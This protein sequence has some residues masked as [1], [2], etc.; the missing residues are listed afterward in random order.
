M[1]ADRHYPEEAPRRPIQVDGFWIDPT[2]VTNRQFSGFVEATGWVTLAE[3][4]ADPKDYPGADPSMLIPASSVF[5]PTRGPV[6]LSNHLNW[7]TYTPGASWRNPLGPDSGLEG[8][9]DHPVVHVALEDVTEAEWE[10]A[11]WGGREDAEYAWGDELEPDGKHH[12]NVWQGRFPYENTAADGWVRTSP[13][14]AY[15][16]N[17]FG[18]YDMIGNVWEWT[19]DWWSVA[20]P[21]PAKSCCAPVNPR[22]GAKSSSGDPLAP[23]LPRRV[24]KGG[25][26]SLRAELLPPIPACSPSSTS[27]R[28]LDFAY[29]LSVREAAAATG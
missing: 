9:E 23:R 14:K 22:G 8:L 19:R 24:M 2:L 10:Y 18:L 13:V 4:P 29:R 11:A 26:P 3:R 5:T 28:H 21:P 27:R 16:P 1:G 17:G 6:D 12:A 7:W 25:S 20:A 15:A